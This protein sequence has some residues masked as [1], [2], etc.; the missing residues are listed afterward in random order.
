MAR[1]SPGR[2]LTMADPYNDLIIRDYFGDNGSPRSGNL[3]ASPDVSTR[4]TTQLP[5]YQ[6]YLTTGGIPNQDIGKDIIGYQAN[7]LFVRCLNQAAGAASGQVYLYYSPSNL[8]MAPG[9][10]SQNQI[11]TM[12]G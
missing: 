9:L 3:S 11:T 2:R 1:P 6:T 12:N 10:W 4:G 5:N 8:L 7:Y